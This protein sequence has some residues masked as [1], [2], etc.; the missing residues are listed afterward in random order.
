MLL[1]P[2]YICQQRY[3]NNLQI[4]LFKKVCELQKIKT[5]KNMRA[6]NICDFH[7]LS[8]RHLLALPGALGGV[9]V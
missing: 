2:G 8:N 9:T 6:Q 1:P 3:K 7:F 4:Q 5:T